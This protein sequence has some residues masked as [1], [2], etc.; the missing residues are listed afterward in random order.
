MLVWGDHDDHIPID[1]AFRLRDSMPNA[2][3]IVFR[4]CGHLPPAEYP[5]KFVE[6]LADFCTT[7]KTE[8]QKA[9]PLEFKRSNA[10]SPKQ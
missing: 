2:R 1:D 7:T 6:A 3:L 10:P 4:N 5:D 9:Q 8:R